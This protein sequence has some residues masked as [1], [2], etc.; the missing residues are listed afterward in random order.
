MLQ[1]SKYLNKWFGFLSPPYVARVLWDYQ[2]CVVSQ[3]PKG[4]ALASHLRVLQGGH[5]WFCSKTLLHGDRCGP[6]SKPFYGN[7]LLAR[8]GGRQVPTLKKAPFTW[9]FLDKGLVSPR[10]PADCKQCRLHTLLLNQRLNIAYFR[11]HVFMPTKWT[12]RSHT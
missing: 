5:P 3:F 1:S 4:Q 12:S 10:D 2:S 8:L 9:M 11:E 6:L 7:I